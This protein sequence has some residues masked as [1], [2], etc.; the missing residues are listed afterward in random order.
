MYMYYFPGSFHYHGAFFGKNIPHSK[1][2]YKLKC[3][4]FFN[5]TLTLC[6]KRY[7]YVN[8]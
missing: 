6:T 2:Y 3:F 7:I 1:T 5:V 8:S 4:S